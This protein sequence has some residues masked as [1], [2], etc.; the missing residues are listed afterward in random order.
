[1]LTRFAP[2]AF[3][4][5]ISRVRSVTA[6]SMMFMIPMPATMSAMIPITKAAIFTPT[7]ILLNWVIRLW[8]LKNSKLSSSPGFRPRSRRRTCRVSSIASSISS[9]VLARTVMFTDLGKPS[10]P[11]RPYVFT[12]VETGIRT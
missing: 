6:T 3:R 7:L 5:P 9:G 4:I 11:T 12:K 8:L 2:S 1:M 10:R